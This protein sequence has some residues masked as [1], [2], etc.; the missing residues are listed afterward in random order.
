MDNFIERKDIIDR[1]FVVDPNTVLTLMTIA[2][3]L[4]DGESVL[5]II[6]TYG[7]KYD[8]ATRAQLAEVKQ[9]I[10][11]AMQAQQAMQTDIN[12]ELEAISA[13]GQTIH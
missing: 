12:N 11:P 13:I 1:A 6:D 3:I 7:D 9:V 2:L 4:G 5:Y 8:E 10:E